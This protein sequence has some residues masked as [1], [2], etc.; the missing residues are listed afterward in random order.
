MF[1]VEDI[2]SQIEDI[3]YHQG[4]MNDLSGSN[5]INLTLLHA[6]EALTSW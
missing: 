5:P 2:E 4:D 1:D 6:F 3:V